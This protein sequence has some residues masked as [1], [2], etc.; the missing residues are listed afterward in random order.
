MLPLLY[1]FQVFWAIISVFSDTGFV[2]SLFF[3]HSV[4]SDSLWPHGLQHN[5]LPCPSLSPGACSNLC[6]TSRWCH[7]T[8]SSPAVPSPPASIFPSIRVFSNESAL[9]I[10]WPKYWSFSFNIVLPLNMQ[11]WFPLALTGLIS[12]QSKGLSRVF[13]NTTVRKYQ[14]FGAQPSLW[15]WDYFGFH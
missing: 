2:V 12:L 7:P 10:R 11:G 13:S 6:P 1:R 9:S 3:S 14:F 5:R 8:I 4:V 15:V